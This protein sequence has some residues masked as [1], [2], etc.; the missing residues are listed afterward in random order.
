MAKRPRKKAPSCWVYVLASA[1]GANLRTYVGWSTDP[2]ARL[3]RHNAGR[4]AK[5]TRGRFWTLIHLERS[6]S[7]RAAMSR[8]WHLKRDRDFR[9]TLRERFRERIAIGAPG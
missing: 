3:Q 7:R 6:A 8:E 5:S 2:Q 4:G 1:R 9:R